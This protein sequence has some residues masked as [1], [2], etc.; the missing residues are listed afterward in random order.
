MHL[1]SIEQIN[2]IK[3]ILIIQLG[4]F[5]DA[6]LTTSYLGSL[7]KH[8]PDIKIYYLIKERYS[9][10]I[11]H[12]PGIDHIINLKEGRG[13]IY[14]WNRL[15]AIRAIRREYFDLVI[16]QQNMPSTQLITL[17]SGARY[18]LGYE[19]ARFHQ[20]YNLKAK[21]G[22]LRYSASRKFDILSPLGIQ[23]EPF[24]LYFHIGDQAFAYI[25]QWLKAGSYNPDQM[26]VISPGSPKVQKNWDLKQYARLADLIQTRTH[27]KVILLWAPNEKDLVEKVA[28]HMETNPI[29][30]PP[31][32]LNQAA[33][34]LKRCKMLICNDGG[35]NHLSVTT[36]TLTLAIFG[37]TDPLVWSPASIS[38]H[39][40]H[41]HNPSFNSGQN[42]SFGVTA[43]E[44]FNKVEEILKLQRV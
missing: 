8:L 11:E 17:L 20:V 12:H 30:A 26:I 4:P 32:N 10:I 44:V 23:E 33:A 37:P 19:D 13:W 16:D 21:R 35:L 29:I 6:L 43:Q 2:R 9:K 28:S 36:Q 38:P 41:I 14:L 40:F 7:K 39:H 25:D 3:K 24:H 34:L 15:Q 22:P 42:N 27:N 1:F 18:R 31:T 5:G